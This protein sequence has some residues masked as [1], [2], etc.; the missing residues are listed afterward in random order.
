MVLAL[1]Y[2][3]DSQFCFLFVCFAS[4]FF[5]FFLIRSDQQ[6]VKGQ[7][8]AQEPRLNVSAGKILTI[9]LGTGDRLQNLNKPYSSQP[10]RNY[11][12]SQLAAMQF[13]PLHA[14][15]SKILY[16]PT[17]HLFKL[18]LWLF[19]LLTFLLRSGDRNQQQTQDVK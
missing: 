7:L 12:E 14:Q 16:I 18:S 5:L 9:K 6:G 11:N 19:C 3:R 1:N 13:F 17:Q 10:I 15:F 2:N 8:K 4:F